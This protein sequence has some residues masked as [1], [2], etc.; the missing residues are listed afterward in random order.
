MITADTIAALKTTAEML[1]AAGVCPEGVTAAKAFAIILAGHEMGFAPMQ[2]IRSIALVKGKVSLSAD[3]TIAVCVRE[4]AVCEY[5]RLVESS[6]EQAVYVTQRKGHPAPVALTYTFEQARAAG[7]TGSGTW[8]AH[9]QAMLRARCGA[10]LARAV[11]PDLVA[12]V[13]DPDEAEEIKRNGKPAPEEKGEEQTADETRAVHPLDS[14]HAALPGLAGADACV[15]LWIEH[16]AAL[17]AATENDR[18]D[19]WTKLVARVVEL[20]GTKPAASKAWLKD[21]LAAHDA[22]ARTREPGDDDDQPDPPAGGAGGTSGAR[23]NG[24]AKGGA[25]AQAPASGPVGLVEPWMMGGEESV[26]GYLAQRGHWNALGNAVRK[27]D[28]AMPASLRARWRL[29]AAWR[30]Q[31]LSEAAIGKVLPLD[32]DDGCKALVKAWAEQGPARGEAQRKAAET[33]TTA[34]QLGM[35][36]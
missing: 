5:F 27:H 31:A 18:K 29:L 28:A 23:T 15:A 10:A 17:S 32:G 11:Y 4:P 36:A 1:H 12:G 34:T 13:Y 16:R 35:V 21:Q 7:L 8:K 33:V 25:V 24:A 3:A 9:P 22:K 30:L 20:S 14:F 6:A 26:R 2:S 19:A